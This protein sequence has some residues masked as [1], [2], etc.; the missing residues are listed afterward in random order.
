MLIGRWRPEEFDRLAIRRAELE[1]LVLVS[2]PAAAMRM[3]LQELSIH[4]LSMAAVSED[5]Q[6]STELLLQIPSYRS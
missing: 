4:R 5:Y 1:E 6:Q 3:L 2:K